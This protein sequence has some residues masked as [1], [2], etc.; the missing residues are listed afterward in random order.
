MISYNIM[1]Y[2]T[3]IIEKRQENDDKSHFSFRFKKD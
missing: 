3:F 1:H 2:N